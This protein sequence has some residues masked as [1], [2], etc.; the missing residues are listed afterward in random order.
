MNT[1]GGGWGEKERLTESIREQQLAFLFLRESAVVTHTLYNY[2]VLL[3]LPHNE[4]R[5]AQM[6]SIRSPGPL[7]LNSSGPIVSSILLGLGT[8][9]LEAVFLIHRHTQH[10]E[11]ASK[12]FKGLWAKLGRHGTSANSHNLPEDQVRISHL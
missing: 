2:R 9:Q 8:G 10:S 3:T 11:S 4:L 5:V 1:E 6:T 7:R 12:G